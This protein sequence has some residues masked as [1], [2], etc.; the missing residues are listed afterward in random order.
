M[1]PHFG[2]IL[3]YKSKEGTLVPQFG[4]LVG[5]QSCDVIRDRAGRGKDWLLRMTDMRAKQAQVCIARAVPMCIGPRQGPCS[6]TYLR[7]CTRMTMT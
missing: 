5:Y 3:L 2:V 7:E 1:V 6:R 4:L